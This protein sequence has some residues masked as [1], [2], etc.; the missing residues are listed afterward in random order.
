MIWEKLDENRIYLGLSADSADDVFEK[1]G[2]PLIEQGFAK[3]NY[4]EGLKARE[5]EFPT[6]LA[7]LIG[8]AIPHTSADCVKKTTFSIAVLNK[9]VPFIEMGT[10]DDVVEVEVVIMLTIAEAHGQIDMLQRVIGIIQDA[11]IVK[12]I[13]NAKDEKKVIELIKEK[14]ETI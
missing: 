5:A 11:D 3:S 1:M 14:E 13:R 2:R 8:T 4:V 6:G 12:E 10:D 9:P 7:T